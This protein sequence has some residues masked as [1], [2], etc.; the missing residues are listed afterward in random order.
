MEFKARSWAAGAPRSRTAAALVVVAVAG[1][2]VHA[3]PG[4]DTGKR[5]AAGCS[6]I[7]ESFNDDFPPSQ[8]DPFHP[9]NIWFDGEH[10]GTI[11]FTPRADFRLCEIEV[12]AAHT[13]GPNTFLVVLYD[14]ADGLPAN[15]PIRSWTAPELPPPRGEVPPVS[16]DVSG[17]GIELREG[18]PYWIGFRVVDYSVG[19]IHLST[20][21]GLKAP[22]AEII[23]SQGG[24]VRVDERGWNPNPGTWRLSGERLGGVECAGR[25]KIRKAQCRQRRGA[26]ELLVKLT[27]G[28]PGDLFEVT[29]SGG[30]RRGG[31]I[32]ERGIGKARFPDLESGPGAATA[33]WD[34]GAEDRRDYDCP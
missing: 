30:A 5:D 18:R 21:P 12:T 10:T 23:A 17:D 4:T 1:P 27:G 26:N 8:V 13:G 3:R 15:E 11:Q 9:V 22:R 25:E 19:H 20:I 34:C 6:V 33:R 28:T 31:A 2:A 32:N 29:I 7:Y 24:W 16:L 14:D